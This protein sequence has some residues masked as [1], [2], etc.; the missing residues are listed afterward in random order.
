MDDSQP[1][2][3]TEASRADSSIDSNDLEISKTAICETASKPASSFPNQTV[4]LCLPSGNSP[5]TSTPALGVGPPSHTVDIS[6]ITSSN[7]TSNETQNVS[8]SDKREGCLDDEI[9][10]FFSEELIFTEILP[11]SPCGEPDGKSPPKS[12]GLSES[13]DSL[14]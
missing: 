1:S 5:S 12:T 14:L 11:K 9:A 13:E 8:S 6:A 10:D 3:L 2:Q 4:P 7:N